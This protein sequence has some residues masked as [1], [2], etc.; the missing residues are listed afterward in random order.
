MKSL[1]TRFKTTT[2]KPNII[3]SNLRKDYFGSW[4]KG[5]W[6]IMGRKVWRRNG[7]QLCSRSV[8]HPGRWRSRV[9]ESQCPPDCPTSSR[10]APLPNLHQLPKQCHQLCSNI[11]S[12]GDTCAYGDIEHFDHNIHPNLQSCSQ[13][14]VFLPTKNSDYSRREVLMVCHS[15]EQ[16]WSVIST[17]KVANCTSW[18]LLNQRWGHFLTMGLRNSED[19][20][21]L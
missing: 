19:G 3:R 18:V 4:F 8:R 1:K 16:A 12:Y 6:C 17:W 11:C 7:S 13:P 20:C 15:L 9:I 10:Q 21:M 14:Q 5:I 2:K